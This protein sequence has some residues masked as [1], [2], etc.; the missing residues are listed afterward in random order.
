MKSGHH[1]RRF[2]AA[3]CFWSHN[4]RSTWRW[5]TSRVLEQWQGRRL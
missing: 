3:R 5:R 4:S 2:R 1:R